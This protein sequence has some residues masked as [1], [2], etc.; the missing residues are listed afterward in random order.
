MHRTRRQVLAGLAGALAWPAL[1]RAAETQPAEADFTFV[2]SCDTHACL[3]HGGL[4]PKCQAEGKTDESLRRHIAAIN[5]IAG[6]AWPNEIGDVPTRLVSA[7]HPIGKPSALVM[8]GDLTD[9]GGG[10]VAIPGEGTQLQQFSQRYQK[11]DEPDQIHL[12]VY[13]GLGNHDLDQDGPPAHRD[14]YRR[15]MRDYVA[16]NHRQTVFYKPPLPATNYDVYSDN[17][18]W[19][20]GG[21]HLVQAERFGGDS[22]K[23]AVDSLP[24]LKDD[25]MNNAADGRPVIL[26][27][28]YGWDPFSRERWDPS[29]GTYTPNGSGPPH[30]WSEE[31]RAA[32]LAVVAGYNV[33][34]I[35]HGHEH[36]TPMIYRAGGID[37]FKPTAAYLGGFAVVRV[38]GNF[39][40]VALAEARGV[41]GEV[42]FL[43]AFSKPIRRG[44]QQQ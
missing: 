24:W 9:D 15:E 44:R 30:W 25:L 19:D 6:Y 7:G 22:S 5:G 34:G 39:M 13:L 37:V 18:S 8:G 16:L 20:W 33:I 12:P 21:L 29:A 32:L 31:D 41:N 43:K 38:G 40:D 11:G 2:F 1:G 17:Y 23:G 42:V 3:M 36:P 10:Q 35:F 4:A 26:F 28:H 27:Q 14:W